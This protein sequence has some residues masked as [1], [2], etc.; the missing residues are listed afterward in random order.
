MSLRPQLSR[1]CMPSSVARVADAHHVLALEFD[2]RSERRRAREDELVGHFAQV[3]VV[4]VGEPAQNAQPE[5]LCTAGVVHYDPD[6]DMGTLDDSART[7][8]Q[9]EQV[10]DADAVGIVMML[11]QPQCGAEGDEAGMLADVAR[12]G[13]AEQVGSG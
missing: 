3:R 13:H 11:H 5:A 2:E 4:S 10:A 8:R 9:R 7:D 1:L 12:A 6:F